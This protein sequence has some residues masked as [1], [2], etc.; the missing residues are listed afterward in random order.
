IDND[1]CHSHIEDIL[2]KQEFLEHY[3][4]RLAPY[5]PMLNPIEK[6]WSVIKSEITTLFIRNLNE[7]TQ[8]FEIKELFEKKLDDK[9]VISRIRKMKHYAFVHFKYRNTAS[10]I[11]EQ[12]QGYI[13]DGNKIEIQWSKPS[14]Q[15][16]TQLPLPNMLFYVNY[17]SY[18]SR[19]CLRALLYGNINGISNKKTPNKKIK[20]NLTHSTNYSMKSTSK[21]QN[22]CIIKGECYVKPTSLQICL[23][24]NFSIYPSRES[25]VDKF[26]I[27][28]C[29]SHILVRNMK[30]HNKYFYDTNHEMIHLNSFKTTSYFDN[31]YVTKVY[32]SLYNQKPTSRFFSTAVNPNLRLC[33]VSSAISK[34]KYCVPSHLG[35][36]CHFFSSSQHSD[37]IGVADGVGGW[38]DFGINPAIYPTALM[39]SCH[40]FVSKEQFNPYDPLQLLKSAY[41]HVNSLEDTIVGSCTACIVVVT[42]GILMASNVGDSGYF[43]IRDGKIIQRS[44]E[45]QYRFNTPYQLSKPPMK[46]VKMISNTPTDAD[47]YKLGIELNDIILIATDGLFD[48]MFNIEILE[49]LK[50]LNTNSTHLMQHMQDV[51]NNIVKKAHSNAFDS[52]WMSPFAETAHQHGISMKGGKPDDITVVLS[53]VI[54]KK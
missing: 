27:S 14:N 51:V 22:Q 36:D 21:P 45:Q 1:L 28:L 10:I 50:S 5:S 3:I 8:E 23:N 20:R 17:F 11:M 12:F 9:N 44:K 25:H 2:S 7:N 32:P 31:N 24:W 18:L 34:Y 6:V 19:N 52:E 26:D 46:A 49:N 37:V 54:L 47:N 41:S 13:L 15:E 43:V 16:Y 42:D 33:T 35:E 4:L 40:Y 39:E 38:K 29:K 30:Q 48:N 53:K